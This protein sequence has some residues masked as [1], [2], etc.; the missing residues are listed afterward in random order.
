M[1]MTYAA[2]V[3]I[4]AG[5][6]ATALASDPVPAKPNRDASALQP[7]NDTRQTVAILLFEG[8][9]LM[10]FAGPAEVFSLANK[11]R[12]FAVVTVAESTKP[13]K[14]MGGF[15]LVPD[16]DFASAPAATVLVVPG[17]N[18]KAVGKAGRDWIKKASGT[19]GIT[20]SVCFGAFL[21]ADVGLLDGIEATTHRWGIKDLQTTAPKCRVVADKRFVDSGKI[22]TTAGVTAGIDGALHVVGR[23]FGKQAEK[24]IAEE[25]M[26]HRP[27]APAKPE[28]E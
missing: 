23:L 3:T 18:L 12:A 5:L 26:E 24:W 1:T 16:H 14:A 28:G 17:G 4:L 11:G 21:L 20:M 2:S 19:A 27:P 8:V 25:W 7:Q 22:V 15:T 13:L 6:L 9:E 10:D